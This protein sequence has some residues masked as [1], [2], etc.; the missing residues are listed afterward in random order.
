M[1][2]R[3][4]RGRVAGLVSPSWDLG[5]VGGQMLQARTGSRAYPPHPER[6]CQTWVRRGACSG[7]AL[8]PAEPRAAS[9]A[10]HAL[11]LWSPTLLSVG[12][13]V[14]RAA[15]RASVLSPSPAPPLGLPALQPCTDPFR[16]SAPCAGPGVTPAAGSPLGIYTLEGARVPPKGGDTLAHAARSPSPCPDPSAGHSAGPGIPHCVRLLLTGGGGGGGTDGQAVAERAQVLQ[17]FGGQ[18]EPPLS[19]FPKCARPCSLPH[20]AL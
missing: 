10:P 14:P 7:L 12:D 9:V 4:P 2:T 20:E 1:G 18:R 11:A 17:F 8:T 15:G 6:R 16:F 13:A 3:R 19:V 5:V